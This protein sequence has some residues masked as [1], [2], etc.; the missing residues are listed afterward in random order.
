[1]TDAH[2][3]AGTLTA[4]R[5]ARIVSGLLLPFG[6][7]C[8]SNLGKFSIPGPDV[9]T[10]PKDVPGVMG[11]NLEHVREASTGRTLTAHNTPAGVYASFR[12]AEGDAGDTLL[13]RWA[14]PNDTDVPRKLSA[15]VADVVIRDGKAVS[16][17]LFGAAFV[18]EGAFPS[19]TLMAAAD[20]TAEKPP[21]AEPVPDVVEKHT[22]EITGEDGITR[23]K[24]TTVTTHVEG[25]KTTTT[26][27]EEIE[28][29]AEPDPTEKEPPV[30]VASKPNTLNANKPSTPKGLSFHAFNRMLAE[31]KGTGN[32]S[33]YAAISQ[34]AS[35]SESLFAALKDIKLGDGEV[36]EAIAAIPQ[37]LGELWSGRAFQRRII[38]LI[39][40]APLT[41]L[42]IAGWR[43]LDKPTVAPWT[44]NK[45]PVPS[46]TP[47]T[48]SYE[49]TAKRLAGAH[50][51]AREY[52]DFDVP[53]FWDGYW[54]GMTES[55]DKQ[56]DDGTLADLL[57][58][59]TPVVRGTVPADVTPGMVSIVDGALE[60]IDEG[61]PSFAV[62]AK[63]LY[64]EILLTRDDN[65]LTYL[66]AALGLEEGTIQ[67]FRVIPHASMPNGTA[68]V[69]AK[70]AATSHELPGVPIRVEGLDMVKG[71]ID[72]GL[73]GYYGT[74][75]HDEAALALVSPPG[76]P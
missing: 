16:G 69:G 56:A 53:G 39:G 47:E 5:E 21:P 29:P 18:R 37:W 42:K 9:I 30:A 20:D 65:T 62:V 14:D 66:N 44:G 36:G 35:S 28:E 59:A 32:A 11:V 70:E 71:G 26:T 4:N 12:I 58:A 41:G 60:I 63:D 48:E 27:V 74:V 1:M 55:Y 3:M 51:V 67:S 38:P 19:A 31:A 8:A 22:E 49:T 25:D 72:P 33:L 24:T 23:T 7:E 6:E 17:R 52:R 2:I 46:N 10:I 40:S 54:R 68:L 13:A 34:E 43:W 50:D 61:L 57:A 64:R 73:F 76:A 15:E 45:A 75:I